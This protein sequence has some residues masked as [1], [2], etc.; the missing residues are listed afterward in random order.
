MDFEDLFF[1][2]F[3]GPVQPLSSKGCTLDRGVCVYQ[4]DACL[5]HNLAR[6]IEKA[7]VVTGPI[8][9]E[10]RGAHR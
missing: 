2:A 10:G 3:D 9:D 1:H 7:L 5:M 6:F 8:R 4:V